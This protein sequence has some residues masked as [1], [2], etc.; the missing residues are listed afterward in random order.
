MLDFKNS[1]SWT[2]RKR[3]WPNK[4][5]DLGVSFRNELCNLPVFR[6]A[7]GIREKGE[8]SQIYVLQWARVPSIHMYVCCM[9]LLARHT[10][11]TFVT[12]GVPTAFAGLDC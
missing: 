4:G 9:V 8:A 11:I 3:E 2:F 1:D 7:E 10:A 12:S 6:K 5:T